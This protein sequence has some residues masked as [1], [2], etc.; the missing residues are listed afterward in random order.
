MLRETG[1]KVCSD[2]EN[3][4]DPM[5]LKTM[6]SVNLEMR[7]LVPQERFQQHTAEFMSGVPALQAAEKS[8]KLRK[9]FHMNASRSYCGRH[10]RW[11]APVEFM[12]DIPAPQ[13]AEEPFVDA[14]KGVP[15]ERFQQCTVEQV[16]DAPVPQ[17]VE[18]RASYC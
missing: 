5:H 3:V 14:V 6:M 12:S 16:V 2:P 13:A 9:L 4:D 18:D 17:I 11:S 8:W 15:Q 7:R 10:R 1:R